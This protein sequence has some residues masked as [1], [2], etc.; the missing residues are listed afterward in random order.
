MPGD[1]NNL[2]GGLTRSSEISRQGTVQGRFSAVRAQPVTSLQGASHQSVASYRRT[3]RRRV[4]IV[5]D[6]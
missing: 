3:T 2:S 4:S 6:M 5:G 1:G